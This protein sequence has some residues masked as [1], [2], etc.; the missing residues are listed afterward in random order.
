V[1]GPGCV[2]IGRFLGAVFMD[3]TLKGVLGG[4]YSSSKDELGG[5][6]GEN[7]RRKL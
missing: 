1:N 5:G 3:F 4:K 6:D 2:T 7:A